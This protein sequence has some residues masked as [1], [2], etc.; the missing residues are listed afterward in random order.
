MHSHS[1]Y[2]E[3]LMMSFIAFILVGFIITLA[4]IRTRNTWQTTGEV[5]SVGG[6]GIHVRWEDSYGETTESRI[7]LRNAN[8]KLDVGD[9]VLLEIVDNR[10]IEVLV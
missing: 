4:V 1:R 10:C 7:T 2:G 5:L 6:N 3:I 8:E 9:K